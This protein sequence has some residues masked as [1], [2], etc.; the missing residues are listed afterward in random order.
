MIDLLGTLATIILFEA[1][2]LGPLY[3]ILKL[4]KKALEEYFHG[5]L[6]AYVADFVTQIEENPEFLEKLLE[7]PLSSLA[8]KMMK[9]IPGIEAL[10]G[11]SGGGSGGDLAGTGLMKM[12]PKEM[13]GIVGIV[14]L[15]SGLG[16]KKEGSEASSNPFG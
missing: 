16:K 8:E 10:T 3:I 6:S 11:S 4:R 9:R 1:V 13:R 2:S 12:V 7:K 15:L 5:L 14:Q